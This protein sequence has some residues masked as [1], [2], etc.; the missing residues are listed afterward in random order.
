MGTAENKRFC[1]TCQILKT[2]RLHHCRRS[3]QCVPSYDHYC[4]WLNSAVGRHNYRLFFLQAFYGCILGS[5][6]FG[7]LLYHLIVSLIGD[8]SYMNTDSHVLKSKLNRI[9]AKLRNGLDADWISFPYQSE[10]YLGE[11][12]SLIDHRPINMYSENLNENRSLEM[13]KKLPSNLEHTAY[14]SSEWI[15]MVHWTQLIALVFTISLSCAVFICLGE[16]S[17]R[18]FRYIKFGITM[19]D[20]ND[21]IYS[22]ELA[23]SNIKRILGDNPVMWFVPLYRKYIRNIGSY[24]G[25]YDDGKEIILE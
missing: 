25:F 21:I 11:K 4:P 10:T 8:S 22:K 18:Y 14:V 2:G 17:V 16:L 23:L 13:V 9:R 20:D 15:D 3:K 6:V 24:S 12:Q 5:F 7:T 19:M 1:Q